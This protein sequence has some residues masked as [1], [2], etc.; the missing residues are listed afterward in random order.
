MRFSHSSILARVNC[1]TV[2]SSRSMSAM[3]CDNS[4]PRASRL[5][6]SS[7]QRLIAPRF[8]RR[9]DNSLRCLF[10]SALA[11]C[12]ALVSTPVLSVEMVALMSAICF[13]NSTHAG[14]S[15]GLMVDAAFSGIASS[16]VCKV[17]MS[18]FNCSM[19]DLAMLMASCRAAT[20]F[21]YPAIIAPSSLPLLVISAHLATLASSNN[22]FAFAIISSGKACPQCGHVVSPAYSLPFSA[23]HSSRNVDCF[24]RAF[25]MS[26]L[27]RAMSNCA[28]CTS[29]RFASKSP[30][31]TWMVFTCS[32]RF[33]L[34]VNAASCANDFASNTICCA[35]WV[36]LFTRFCLTCSA[37]YCLRMAVFIS[38]ICASISAICLSMSAICASMAAK[39]SGSGFIF[40]V[41]SMRG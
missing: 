9:V 34:A 10:K 33:A 22:C 16:S 28:F 7:S 18:A 1:S 20:S 27:M 31:N 19:L 32:R 38:A 35:C 40:W 30:C 24:S 17:L 12:N 15:S 25:S 41:W 39:S 29:P 21:S 37:S 6:I 8:A 13:C 36:R 23:N 4:L 5:V 2:Y 3:A 11:V 14:I 26:R